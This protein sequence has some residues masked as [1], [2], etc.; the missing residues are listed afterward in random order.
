MENISNLALKLCKFLDHLDKQFE[1]SRERTLTFPQQI[2][3]IKKNLNLHEVCVYELCNELNFNNLEPISVFLKKLLKTYHSSILQLTNS[4]FQAIIA[5]LPIDRQGEFP[6][7]SL[8]KKINT[9]AGQKDYVSEGLIQNKFESLYKEINL[10]KEDIRKKERLIENL[11]EEI[12]QNHL[13]QTRL[14][15]LC[16]REIKEHLKEKA[17]DMHLRTGKPPLEESLSK[18]KGQKLEKQDSLRKRDL[19]YI[20][21]EKQDPSNTNNIDKQEEKPENFDNFIRIFDNM[22]SKELRVFEVNLNRAAKTDFTRKNTYFNHNK[23]ITNSN[24]I[25]LKSLTFQDSSIINDD[26]EGEASPMTKEYMSL[27]NETLSGKDKT[28]E[29]AKEAGV[30]WELN[31]I[32]QL[33][34]NK[35]HEYQLRDSQVNTI[36]HDQKEWLP[37]MNSSM[38]S[39]SYI[40][41][42]FSVHSSKKDKKKKKKVEAIEEKKEYVER[43]IDP[44]EFPESGEI[45]AMRLEIPLLKQGINN[46]YQETKVLNRT[47]ENKNKEIKE[48]KAEIQICQEKTY[49]EIQANS[50]LKTKIKELEDAIESIRVQNETLEEKLAKKKEKIKVLKGKFS[51]QVAREQIQDSIKKLKQTIA[52]LTKE[53]TNLKAII[54]NYKLIFKHGSQNSNETFDLEEPG[55]NNPKGEDNEYIKRANMGLKDRISKLEK[56]L[57]E[58]EDREFSNE[59]QLKNMV[60]RHVELMQKVSSKDNDKTLGNVDDFDSYMK[61]VE[62]ALGKKIRNPTVSKRKEETNNQLAANKSPEK[63]G[64]EGKGDV[65]TGR[66]HQKSI[67]KIKTLGKTAVLLAKDRTKTISKK[68][69]KENPKIPDF[70]DDKIEQKQKSIHEVKEKTSTKIESEKGISELSNPTKRSLEALIDEEKTI[71]NENS[72]EDGK[73]SGKESIVKFQEKNGLTPIEETNE[74]NEDSGTGKQQKLKKS[75][76]LYD[77]PK[78][79]TNISPYIPGAVVA[80]KTKE[81]EQASY[82]SEYLDSVKQKLNDLKSNMQNLKEKSQAS[83]INYSVVNKTL[84]EFIKKPKKIEIITYPIDIP[85]QRINA[86][87]S[88]NKISSEKLIEKTVQ[89]ENNSSKQIHMTDIGIQV[90]LAKDIR[91]H[92]KSCQTDDFNSKTPLH[93]TSEAKF[94]NPEI[95]TVNSNYIRRT[96]KSLHDNSIS[97]ESLRKN[98]ELA[99]ILLKNNLLSQSEMKEARAM[100]S[101]P[102]KI[103]QKPT[104]REAQ[105]EDEPRNQESGKIKKWMDEEEEV[106]QEISNGKKLPN[107]ISTTNKSEQNIIFPENDGNNEKFERYT[108]LL[109]KKYGDKYTNAV[110]VVRKESDL[111]GLKGNLNSEKMEQTGDSNQINNDPYQINSET[112]RQKNISEYKKKFDNENVKNYGDDTTF[113]ANDQNYSLNSKDKRK[114]PTIDDTQDQEGIYEILYKNL[115]KNLENPETFIKS[116]PKSLEDIFNELL[117]LK[118]EIQNEDAKE[119]KKGVLGSKAIICLILPNYDSFKTFV[120]SLKEKHEGCGKKCPHLKRFYEKLGIMKDKQDGR[121]QVLLHKR[122]MNKLPK[123]IKSFL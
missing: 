34:L 4:V 33:I 10:Q 68:E 106:H 52:D 67:N 50:P 96:S 46:L 12:Q 37:H 13:V 115:E 19:L 59:M 17:Y 57:R 109:A 22:V 103:T 98:P 88:A 56:A 16:L 90:Y 116:I 6:L 113:R 32:L 105:S 48:L 100:V 14:H 102:S 77:G 36:K 66:D 112:K 104:K 25:L 55:N 93:T 89:E 39:S 86:E 62:S 95:R 18:T 78:K 41:N 47:I 99:K 29:G 28:L 73:T 121:Q 3:I 21:K 71:K 45:Q 61:T 27:L 51:A 31:R 76:S 84:E 5:R 119:L 87:P 74:K 101:K 69:P 117:A 1:A 120:K 114:E 83:Q 108:D 70:K 85:R 91:T 64:K 9:E 40:R 80:K 60:E 92:N 7:Q 23:Q 53:N 43:G 49:N 63:D 110:Y 79:T 65:K 82:P 35:R 38:S 122:D 58:A 42:Q 2:D 97:E 111:N 94:A 44:I 30:A 24:S 123:L 11:H 72:G 26:A 81:V 75:K 118:A 54:E 20:K 8:N 107:I 15:D